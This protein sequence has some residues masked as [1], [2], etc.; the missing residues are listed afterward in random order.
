[1]KD[2]EQVSHKAF[3]VI[4]VSHVSGSTNL[5]MV[6]YP[7]DHFVTITIK[8]ATLERTLSNDW[9]FGGKEQ[10]QV[11]MSEVQIARLISSPN[12]GDGVPCTLNRYIDPD[13]REVIYPKLPDEHAATVKTYAKEI[14]ESASK[15]S[16]TINKAYDAVEELLNAK[17]VRKGDLEKIKQK[18]ASVK[19]EISNNLPFVVK[20]AEETINKATEHAKSEVDAYLDFALHRLGERAVGEELARRIENE[21]GS[22]RDLA[23]LITQAASDASD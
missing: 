1:M 15:A 9:V 12:R 19:M 6:D 23:G 13:T 7:Q 14:K 8:G 4:G 17:S 22:L 5:F 21:G 10:I 16:E 18:L 2:R 11:S 3:G 20:Q